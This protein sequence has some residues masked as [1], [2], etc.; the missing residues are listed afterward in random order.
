MEIEQYDGKPYANNSSEGRTIAAPQFGEPREKPSLDLSQY[1]GKEVKIA[2][3]DIIEGM[4][5]PYMKVVTET[6]DTIQLSGDPLELRASKVFSLQQLDGVYFLYKDSVLAHFL[7]KMNIAKLA[8]Y[9]KL[10]G[11]KVKVV[12]VEGKGAKAGK[13]FLSF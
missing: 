1:L 4:H 10:V 11:K 12:T 6:V 9:R 8:D 13:T 3:V 7:Q 5:G 2:A